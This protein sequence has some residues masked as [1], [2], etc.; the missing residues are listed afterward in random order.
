VGFEDRTLVLVL[1][2]LR[3]VPIERLEVDGDD[4]SVAF[5][6]EAF[7]QAVSDLAARAGDQGDVLAHGKLLRGPES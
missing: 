4:R 5:R 1:D 3:E 7:D 6:G 2:P